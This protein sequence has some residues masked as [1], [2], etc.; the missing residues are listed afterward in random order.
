MHPGNLIS[1]KDA[2]KVL[3]NQYRAGVS[4]SQAQL[5]CLVHH[6]IL[7]TKNGAY[8]ATGRAAS[9]APG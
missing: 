5:D 7:E 8:W 2:L 4:L 6:G 1:T 9:L 3:L